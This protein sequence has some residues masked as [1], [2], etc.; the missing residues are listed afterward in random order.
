[1]NAASKRS[2]RRISR[3]ILIVDDHPVLRRGLSSLIESEPDLVVC[4][5]AASCNSALREIK[6]KRPDLVLVDLALEDSD[7]LDLVKQMKKKYPKIPALVLSMYGEEV[8][9]ERSLRAGARGYICKQQ[10]DEKVLTAIHEVLSGNIYLSEHSK[11]LFAQKFTS[12][13][14]ARATSLIEKLSDRELQVFRLIGKGESTRKIAEL[15][16][17]S[18]KTIESHRE[19]I[20]QKLMIETSIELNRRAILWYENIQLGQSKDNE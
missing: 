7:G 5:E 9:A 14:S 8:Y 13:Q 11:T 6:S 1:M 15:L 12:D 17:L 10:L 20:K 19:H 3:N 4:S 16:S 2:A 18:I